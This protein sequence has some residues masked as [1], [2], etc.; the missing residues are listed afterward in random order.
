VIRLLNQSIGGFASKAA[1][2]VV[3]GLAAVMWAA[4]SIAEQ[5]KPAASAPVVP[6]GAPSS[7]SASSYIIGP[8]DLIQIFVWR[9]PELTVT[10]PV[11]P[12]GKVSSPLVEDMVAVGKTPTQ[13]ARDIE[14]RLADYIRSPQVSIIV[15]NAVST[16]SQ[17]KVIGQVKAPQAMAYREGMTVLDVILA[18]GGLTDF[19][20]GNRAKIIRKASDGKET[21]IK[22]RIEDVVVKGKLEENKRLQPGDVIIVPQSL[23]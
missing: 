10:V 20:A 17:I 21:S 22:V 12:D 8:G 7:E 13:L 16:F 4:A 19:A 14:T 18:V 6:E 1:L 9:S 3:A 5:P 2:G 15:N 11:R 23:F